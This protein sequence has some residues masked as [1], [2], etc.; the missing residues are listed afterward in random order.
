M[1]RRRLASELSSV[2]DL[3]EFAA[4]LAKPLPKLS[5]GDCLSHLNQVQAM[6]VSMRRKIDASNSVM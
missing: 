3:E 6:D 4:E 2:I 1:Q 5:Q